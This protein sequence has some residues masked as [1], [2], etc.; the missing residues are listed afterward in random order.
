M[1]ISKKTF[2]KEIEICQ[3]LFK[4]SKGCKWGKCKDCGAV[5][6]LYKLRSGI[7]IEKKKDVKKLKKA[8]LK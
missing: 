2:D 7:V 3:K 5:P 6:L 4:K 8:Y 1:D